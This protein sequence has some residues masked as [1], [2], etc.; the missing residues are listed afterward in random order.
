MCL[1]TFSWDQHPK[2]KLVLLANRD[3][4]YSRATAAASF[5]DDY[6][7]LLGGRDLEAGG[8]WMGMHHSGRFSA[9]TNYRDPQN[10]KE[11]APSRGFLTSDYLIK[12][13]SPYAYLKALHSKANDYNGFNLL[14][15]NLQEIWY[16]SN[17]EH[18][19]RNLE[20][21]LY[22]L[23]NHL[24]DTPWYKAEVARQLLAEAL[25]QD[26]ISVS[27]FLDALHNTQKPADELVQRTGLA[28]EKERMLSSMFIE[29]PN[30]GTHS[31]SV[32]LMTH[33]G[34]LEFTERRYL[35][36]DGKPSEQ[37]FRFNIEN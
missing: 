16:Y 2:Y 31:S 7:K 10:I 21:G 22:A 37:T 36:A 11:Q 6:P 1:I 32:L 28:I 5:W 27:Y 12:N 15:G 30:Y 8:T 18:E 34:E 17:Y 4:F 33:E 25:E 23:S 24:L 13:Q 3:E 9:L 29:S 19:V 26:H 14:V 35:N 20:A